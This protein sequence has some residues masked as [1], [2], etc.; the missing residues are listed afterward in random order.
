MDKLT[1][2][3]EAASNRVGVTDT[4]GDRTLIRVTG[5]DRSAFLHGQ[6]TNE[7]KKMRMGDSCY[8]AFLDPKGKMRGAAHII[9]LADAYLL[10]Y[11]AILS[12]LLEG[13]LKKYI[14]TEDVT[15]E[16]V[17]EAFGELTV[18]GLQA[19]KLTE[20]FQKLGVTVIKNQTLGD[21]S[22]KMII[23]VTQ[24]DKFIDK[25]MNFGAEIISADTLEVI[26]IETGVPKWGVDMDENT[27]PIEAG[28]EKNAISYDKGCY[29]GQ[30]TIARIK[31]YG[32]VNRHL[33]Q[34]GL[35]GDRVPILGEKIRFNE[36]DVGHVT[37]CVKS[38]RIG[39]A[40][41]LGYVRREHA[42]I[43]NQ[44]VIEN[45]TVEVLKLCCV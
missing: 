23:P 6:C 12:P 29:I 28:L 11:P 41:A 39:K 43:G 14:I 25:C 36:K 35:E 17:S 30:E 18:Q 8:A 34:L 42:E 37:S 13:S 45:Q 1:V 22:F 24:M 38:V 26:R 7:V 21:Q 2:E 3:Y 40:L 16:N 4:T 33:V 44:L 15:I 10:D 20:H 27:I 31:T 19:G 9:C 32:H 5:N